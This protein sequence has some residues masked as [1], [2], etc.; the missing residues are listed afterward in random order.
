MKAKTVNPEFAS[1]R[2]KNVFYF[3]NVLSMDDGSSLIFLWSSFH[4]I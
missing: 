3:F 2:K 4:D 1:Q